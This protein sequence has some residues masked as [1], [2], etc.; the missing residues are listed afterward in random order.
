MAGMENLVEN[1]VDIQ[2]AGQAGGA[3]KVKAAIRARVR[4]SRE[5]RVITVEPLKRNAGSVVMVML[6]A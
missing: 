5:S 3:L 2:V 1:Q 4:R 6:M